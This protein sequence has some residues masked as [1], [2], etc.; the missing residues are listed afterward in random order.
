MAVNNGQDASEEILNDAFLSRTTNTS[1]TGKLALRNADSADVEDVQGKIN[2]LLS[3]KTSSDTKNAQQDARLDSLESSL[4][5]SNFN[6]AVEPAASNDTT[7]GYSLGSYWYNA[8]KGHLYIC[9]DAAEDAALW[10]DINVV[11]IK[12]WTATTKYL[13]NETVL[14]DGVIYRA[15]TTFTSGATFDEANWQAIGAAGGGGGGSL[16]TFY[17]ETFEE[18]TDGSEF[19][20]LDGGVIGGGTPIAS[21][22]S[23]E[24]TEPL[25]GDKS[26]KFT[27]PSSGTGKYCLLDSSLQI[28]VPRY[29]RNGKSALRFVADGTA[30]YGDISLFL[31]DTTNAETI[32]DKDGNTL[33]INPRANIGNTLYFNT[34]GTEALQWGA[35]INRD[36]SGAT[37]IVDNVEIQGNP[38]KNISVFNSSSIISESAELVANDGSSLTFNTGTNYVA[39]NI[40]YSQKGEY[41]IGSFSFR[42]GNG[43]AVTGTAGFV[44][45]NLPNGYEYDTSKMQS[46]T[47]GIFDVGGGRGG[48]GSENLMVSPVGDTSLRFIMEDGGSLAV[49]DLIA[50]YVITVSF[51]VPIKGWSDKEDNVIV[52]GTNDDALDRKTFHR[53]SNQSIPNATWTTIVLDSADSQNVGGHVEYDTGTGVLSVNTSG[54]YDTV[55]SAKFSSFTNYGYVDFY[56]V[57]AGVSIHYGQ[58]R[59]SSEEGVIKSPRTVYLEAGKTYLMRCYQDSGSNLNIHGNVATTYMSINYNPSYKETILMY[60]DESRVS[61]TYILDASDTYSV[62]ATTETALREL[63]ELEKSG[64][65]LS[66]NPVNGEWEGL[67]SGRYAFNISAYFSALNSITNGAV[68]VFIEKGGSYYETSLETLANG[69]EVWGGGYIELEITKGETFSTGVW[70]NTGG[71]KTLSATRNRTRVTYHRIL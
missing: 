24:E 25:N 31:W 34:N 43:G 39:P 29:A 14:N 35:F 27:I 66:Y 19:P 22:V 9:T 20:C 5:L 23:I 49:S 69:G 17:S 47:G 3:G 1:T 26:I 50:D 8:V 30:D 42:N 15:I 38:D 10:N 18:F 68:F 41:L 58:R 4:P 2:E 55:V 33:F 71:A 16:S 67:V 7:E 70:H 28:P 60:L 54:W 21:F 57:E 46:V 59:F 40:S 45:V 48:D 65:G 37:L 64:N 6:A 12:D 32:K 61:G 53:S 62:P 63:T 52:A 56:N 36:N 51:K 11:K 13:Q 44:K